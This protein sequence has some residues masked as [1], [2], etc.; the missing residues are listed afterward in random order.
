AAAPAQARLFY[1]VDN[2]VSPALKNGLGTIPRAAC[3]SAG[4]SPVLEAVEVR[5]DAV[6]IGK[7]QPFS[8]NVVAPPIG[9]DDRRPFCGPGDGRSPR[10]MAAKIFSVAGPSRSS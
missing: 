6:L 10:R 3:A 4:Q 9:S 8:F 7:H 2:R 1:L 5:E